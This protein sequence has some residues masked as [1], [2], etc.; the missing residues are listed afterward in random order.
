[1]TERTAPGDVP[2]EVRAERPGRAAARF[3]SPSSRARRRYLRSS[4]TRRGR[5]APPKRNASA[6]ISTTASRLGASSYHRSASGVAT[7]GTSRAISGRRSAVTPPR[8][9]TRRSSV[10]RTRFGRATYASFKARCYATWSSVSWWTQAP[11]APRSTRQSGSDS[12]SIR[13][14]LTRRYASA[15]QPAES[16]ISE[17]ITAAIQPPFSGDADRNSAAMPP[18]FRRCRSDAAAIQPS[19]ATDNCSPVTAST[20][21]RHA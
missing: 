9:R 11:R 3:A 17:T 10:W 2:T 7:W 15:A 4:S 13:R 20:V 14:S 18:Q 21:K 19:P 5:R 1:M 8:S 12:S 16:S 6:T